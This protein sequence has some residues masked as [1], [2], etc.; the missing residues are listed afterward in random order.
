MILIHAYPLGM[1][2]VVS[3]W[4][5]EELVE[6][7]RLWAKSLVGQC[8]KGSEIRSFRLVFDVFMAQ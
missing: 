1:E 8:A 7:A 2:V 5:K 4:R 6:V 3:P